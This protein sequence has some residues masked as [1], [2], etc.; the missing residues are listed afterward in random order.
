LVGKFGKAA[1]VA[2]MARKVQASDVSGV[3]EREPKI[4][5]NFYELVLEAERKAISKRFG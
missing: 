5:D 2:L 4:N 1:I 3:L